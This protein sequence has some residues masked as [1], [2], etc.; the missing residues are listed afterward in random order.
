MPHQPVSGRRLLIA[1][2]GGAGTAA[3]LGAT[4]CAL[5]PLSAE[6][7]K[8]LLAQLIMLEV[9]LVLIAAFSRY[10]AP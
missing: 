4:Y 2:G 10:S 5:R 6:P 8:G 1:L 3:A 9:Y 7:N